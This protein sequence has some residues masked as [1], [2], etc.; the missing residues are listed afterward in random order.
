MDRPALPT[1]RQLAYLVELS[2]HLNF[3]VA[4]EAQFVT[5]YTMSAGICASSSSSATSATCGSP[6]WGRTSSR[7]RESSRPPRGT[8]RRRPAPRRAD[9]LAEF[10]IEQPR[11]SGRARLSPLRR[12]APFDGKAV[13]WMEKVNDEEYAAAAR[14]HSQEAK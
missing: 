5:Q 4:A 14:L 8:W 13:D 12:R 7:A 6:R 10:L 3:R 2:E 9:V 1:L 11:R